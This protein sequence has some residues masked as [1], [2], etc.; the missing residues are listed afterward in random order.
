MAFFQAIFDKCGYF[1]KSFPWKKLFGYKLNLWLFFKVVCFKKL[2]VAIWLFQ[3]ILG[4]FCYFF[5]EFI[6]IWQIFKFFQIKKFLSLTFFIIIIF[7]LYKTE[8]FC[9]KIFAQIRLLY[10]WLFWLFLE[11][12]MAIFSKFN[13][14][15]LIRYTEM[16]HSV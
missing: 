15:T 6:P 14:V 10:K 9:N 8:I 11:T 1:W 12:K 7:T 13:L 5:R 16:P 4:H 3:A 2:L